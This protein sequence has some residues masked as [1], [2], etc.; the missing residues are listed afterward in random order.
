[1]AH[2]PSRRF[3]PPENPA[4]PP[5]AVPALLKRS[6]WFSLRHNGLVCL[7]LEPL[8]QKDATKD[9]LYLVIELM[10]STGRKDKM[11]LF[12][13]QCRGCLLGPAVRWG[14]KHPSGLLLRGP[15]VQQH[16]VPHSGPISYRPNRNPLERGK[17]VSL[18]MPGQAPRP[19]RPRRT[20]AVRVPVAFL[21]RS[22]PSTYLFSS[23]TE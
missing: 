9:L 14:R 11:S 21:R 2:N 1:M 10:N 15:P 18:E 12:S 22:A 23:S 8:G 13:N 5:S 17:S 19:E 7:Q 6:S 4:F 16:P 3:L 20:R